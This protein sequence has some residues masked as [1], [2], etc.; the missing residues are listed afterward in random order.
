M[1]KHEAAEAGPPPKKVFTVHK[2]GTGTVDAEGEDL[3]EV[4]QA[5]VKMAINLETTVKS[6]PDVFVNNKIPPEKFDAS[7]RLA[8][9]AAGNALDYAIRLVEELGRT[10]R[11]RKLRRQLAEEMRAAGLT[12]DPAQE[13]K[14]NA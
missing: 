9:V 12:G 5:I 14:G 7:T 2:D 6:V 4:I 8:F 11:I 10:G 3:M 13:D 1:S